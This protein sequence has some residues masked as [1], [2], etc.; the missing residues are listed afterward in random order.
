[1]LL[2]AEDDPQRFISVSNWEDDASR[3]AW[4][5]SPAY[6]DGI[7]SVKELCDEFQGGNFG[8]AAVINR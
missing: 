8:A 7:E 3:A 1:M 6:G 2:R 4:A 5:Q